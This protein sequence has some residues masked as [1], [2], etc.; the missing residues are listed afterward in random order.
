MLTVFTSG[1][2]LLLMPQL[3]INKLIIP[4]GMGNKCNIF[5]FSKKAHKE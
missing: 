1:S 3:L 5:V 4:N 2:R